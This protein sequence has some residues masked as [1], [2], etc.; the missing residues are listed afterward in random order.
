MASLSEII[1]DE[2][3]ELICLKVYEANDE[4]PSIREQAAFYHVNPNTISKVYRQLENEGFIYSKQAT[5]Y[6]VA[7]PNDLLKKTLDKTVHQSLKSLWL[8]GRHAGYTMDDLI[9][10]MQEEEKKYD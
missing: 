10:M 5:G 8:Y 6:Y 1:K 7:S 2:L 9:K 3:I 4:L